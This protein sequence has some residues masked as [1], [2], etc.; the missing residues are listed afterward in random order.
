MERDQRA[1]RKPH[2]SKKMVR[3][4]SGS[5]YTS[6]SSVDD[7]YRSGDNQ[8]YN[9]DG[10]AGSDSMD[11]RYKLR[12]EQW[13]KEVDEEAERGNREDEEEFDGYNFNQGNPRRL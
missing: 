11:R 3:S 1:R 8:Q 4:D 13:R 7:G 2:F 9:S 12:G 6:D 10:S 5:G